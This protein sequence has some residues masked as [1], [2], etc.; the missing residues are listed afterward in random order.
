MLRNSDLKRLTKNLDKSPR[1]SLLKPE[2][3]EGIK[4]LIQDLKQETKAEVKVVIK[5]NK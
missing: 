1:T 5:K 4:E 3:R 2:E